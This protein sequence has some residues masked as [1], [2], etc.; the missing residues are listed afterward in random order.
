MQQAEFPILMETKAHEK[1]I[2]ISDLLRPGEKPANPVKSA[3]R[4]NP[5]RKVSIARK[6]FKPTKKES[7][8]KNLSV[9]EKQ[10]SDFESDSDS[11]QSSQATFN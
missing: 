3:L 10:H 11:S 8:A 2:T 5:A 1:Q 4:T 7:S 9:E 6:K